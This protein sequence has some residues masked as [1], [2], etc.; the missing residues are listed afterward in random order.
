VA[1]F[2]ATHAPEKLENGDIVARLWHMYGGNEEKLF[3][4][5]ENRYGE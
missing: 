2:Y 3:A 4:K 5:L 1:L